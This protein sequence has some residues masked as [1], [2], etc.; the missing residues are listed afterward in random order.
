MQKVFLKG[1]YGKVLENCP[2][3][4]KHREAIHSIQLILSMTKV[5]SYCL[6][7]YITYMPGVLTDEYTFAGYYRPLDMMYHS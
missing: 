4:S 5:R 2:Q 3:L 1:N 7:H 6:L